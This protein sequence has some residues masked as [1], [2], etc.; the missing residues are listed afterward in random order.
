MRTKQGSDRNAGH[1]TTWNGVMCVM[2]G[3]ELILNIHLDIGVL[4]DDSLS[5]V[6]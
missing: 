3:F 1:G 6:N 2:R 4:G 5:D